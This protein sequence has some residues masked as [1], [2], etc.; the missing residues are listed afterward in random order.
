MT[1]IYLAKTNVAQHTQVRFNYD[2]AVVAL[3]K[4]I[5]VHHRNYDNITRAWTIKGNP[6]LKDFAIACFALGYTFTDP[7]GCLRKAGVEYGHSQPPPGYGTGGTGRRQRNGGAYST[8][9]YGTGGTGG[10]GG[11]YTPPRSTPRS[12]PPVNTAWARTLF[13]ALPTTLHDKAYRAL[14]KVLHPDTGG[15]AELMK[16]LNAERDR[17]KK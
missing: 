16:A 14:A 5:P 15:D 9:G 17:R 3:L 6:Y 2:E 10:T 7:D 4:T 8:G 1:T 11:T 12:T 13:D